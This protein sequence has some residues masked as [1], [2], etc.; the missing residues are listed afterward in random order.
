MF[1]NPNFMS[2]CFHKPLLL[3]R[4][5]VWWAESTWLIVGPK[6]DEP[7]CALTLSSSDTIRFHEL[8]NAHDGSVRSGKA[9]TAPRTGRR[10]DFRLPSRS[11]MVVTGDARWKWQHEIVRSRKGRSGEGWKR[12]SLTF[13]VERKKQGEEVKEV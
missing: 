8:F 6:Q 5:S 3:S 12:V 4:R 9:A 10:V 7:V 2:L 1:G 11:L 13:R